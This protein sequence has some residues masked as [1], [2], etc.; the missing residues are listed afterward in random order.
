MVATPS[1]RGSS[2]SVLHTEHTPLSGY[3]HLKDLL[4]KSLLEK[5]E[6][7]SGLLSIL[8]GQDRIMKEGGVSLRSHW[9]PEE[10]EHAL[11]LTPI[12]TRV[13]TGATQKSEAEARGGARPREEQGPTIPSRKGRWGQLY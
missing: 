4:S 13:S 3:R 11:P 6:A 8:R 1:L 10:A 9:E 2:A 7:G 12:P 5:R